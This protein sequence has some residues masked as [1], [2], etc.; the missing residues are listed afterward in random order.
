M[1]RIVH[2][3]EQVEIDGN[4]FSAI[5]R[6]ELNQFLQE[7]CAAAGVGIEYDALLLRSMR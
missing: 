2:R 1:Q 5:G 4:G 7:L 6:L 3:D